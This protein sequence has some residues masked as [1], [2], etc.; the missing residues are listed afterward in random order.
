[1][2]PVCRTFS[3]TQALR[4]FPCRFTEEYIPYDGALIF[5]DIAAEDIRQRIIQTVIEV[6]REW[7]LELESFLDPVGTEG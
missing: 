2:P 1:M 7:G 5:L 6:C 4:K 3:E